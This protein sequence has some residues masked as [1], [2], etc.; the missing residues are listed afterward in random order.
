MIPVPP[1]RVAS[2]IFPPHIHMS[3]F[4]H[5]RPP[6]QPAHLLWVL[7]QSPA[8]RLAAGFPSKRRGLQ[9]PSFFPRAPRALL[10][11]VRTRSFW[12]LHPDILHPKTFSAFNNPAAAAAVQ[13]PSHVQL[14]CNCQAP[15][16]RVFPRQEYWGGLSFLSPRDFNQTRD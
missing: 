3:S 2:S 12:V 14:F 10:P 7:R 11:M 5:Q 15:L 13:P 1:H 8:H 4:L 6:P 16:S 9:V